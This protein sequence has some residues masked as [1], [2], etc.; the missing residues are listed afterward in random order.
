MSNSGVGLIDRIREFKDSF[1]D[2]A[3]TNKIIVIIIGVLFFIHIYSSSTILT[4]LKTPDGELDGW[5]NIYYDDIGTILAIVTSFLL[6]VLTIAFFLKII[7]IDYKG[8]GLGA[9]KSIHTLLFS[10][11]IV[12][13]IIELF[14]VID[15][16]IPE[17]FISFSVV[18][19]LLV[20]DYLL[21]GR[22]AKFGT[23]S[24]QAK[25]I[26]FV[27]NE[28]KTFW[29]FIDIYSLLIAVILLLFIVL[30]TY[31]IWG[32]YYKNALSRNQW[33]TDRI[34]KFVF[35]IIGIVIILFYLAP[36]SLLL[37]WDLTTVQGFSLDISYLVTNYFANM[38]RIA[39]MDV[40]L[41][42]G[43]SA[44]IIGF[45]QGFSILELLRALQDALNKNSAV[46][47][48]AEKVSSSVTSSVRKSSRR[49]AQQTTRS[50]AASVS[51]LKILARSL[52]VITWFSIFWD[53][54]VTINLF[55][56]DELSINVP[57]LTDYFPRFLT[58]LATVLDGINNISSL[59]F[60]IIVLVILVYYFVTSVFKFT[61]IELFLNELH[62]NKT[63]FYLIITATFVIIIT[64][65]YSDF[66]HN[67]MNIGVGAYYAS[68]LTSYTIFISDFIL[69]LLSDIE[70][71]GFLIGLVAIIPVS[72]K[73]LMNKNM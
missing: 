43:V 57:N 10:V 19:L 71:F 18:T 20:I 6:I 51:K 59:F 14:F 39:E 55:L 30:I 38:N 31:F 12:L 54:L 35:L 73:A 44:L 33:T 49:V 47:Q 46:S 67:F 60:P 11:L 70:A 32:R 4:K 69:K 29:L 16:F 2:S 48:T 1:S 3:S 26:S 41:L 61:S 64:N 40:I 8:F 66:V 68:L 34:A 23:F 63:V 27:D 28:D 56:L 58:S 45:V 13:F 9:K 15:L 37:L 42:V 62:N 21:F 72:V 5:R 52:L 36:V 65:I 7:F 25:Q 22:T 17:V 50:V 53:K 24:F